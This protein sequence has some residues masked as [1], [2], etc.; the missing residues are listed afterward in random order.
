[1]KKRILL[2]SE[3][4]F[5]AKKVAQAQGKCVEEFIE[6]LIKQKTTVVPI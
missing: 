5:T 1:M 6:E 3:V 4:F 2:D